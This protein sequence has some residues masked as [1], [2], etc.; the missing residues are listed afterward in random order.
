M[1]KNKLKKPKTLVCKFIGYFFADT[2]CMF[3]TLES[4]KARNLNIASFSFVLQDRT[5][6][7]TR[8][9][10]IRTHTSYIE[11]SLKSKI[12]PQCARLSP[13]S[14]SVTRPELWTLY[15]IVFIDKPAVIRVQ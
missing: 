14:L 15:N 5:N 12:W 3:I 11:Y 13:F 6:I 4:S 2:L 10:S 1:P 7:C 9:K 8:N